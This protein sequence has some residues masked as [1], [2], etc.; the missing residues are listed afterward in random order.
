MHAP[1]VCGFLTSISRKLSGTLYISSICTM[2]DRILWV[3][4]WLVTGDCGG[5]GTYSLLATAEAWF[6]EDA[7]PCKRR[8]GSHLMSS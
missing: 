3:L 6:V 2:S 8:D 4:I 1:C 5:E 7:A